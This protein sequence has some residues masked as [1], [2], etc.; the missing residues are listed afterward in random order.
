MSS[1]LNWTEHYTS[2]F[3][4]TA[5][6]YYDPELRDVMNGLE[7]VNEPGKEFEYLSGSTQLLGM[8]IEKATGKTLSQ[9]LSESFWKPMGMEQDALWQVDSEDSGMEK[10]YVVLLVMPGI[11]LVL[12]CYLKMM[13]SLMESKYYQRN[14][15]K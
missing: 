6:A 2:P 8:V 5:R 4:I 11:L 13:E 7:V 3:S 9:Y 10:T 15:Q 12:E 1:G 14:L